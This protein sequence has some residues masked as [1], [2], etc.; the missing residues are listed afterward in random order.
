MVRDL[1][2]LVE[3]KLL[4][5]D[6]ETR[7]NSDKI[8]D[9]LKEMQTKSKRHG[10]AYTF[11]GAPSPGLGHSVRFAGN[12]ESLEATNAATMTADI[13]T[14][15]TGKS[16][17]SEPLAKAIEFNNQDG[18]PGKQGQGT[19]QNNERTPLL[20]NVPVLRRQS[21]LSVQSLAQQVSL[22]AQLRIWLQNYL[23]T[24]WEANMT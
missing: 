21:S 6:K 13:P 14:S 10:T 22:T 8:V 19:S 12:T 24:C 18:R 9:A 23:G 7:E 20:G 17:S 1:L 15:R 16:A 3:Q 11:Y 5:V 4:V 2:D